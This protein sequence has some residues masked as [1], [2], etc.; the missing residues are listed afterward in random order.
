MISKIL[1]L[2]LVV[3]NVG[4]ILTRTQIKD[5]EDKA[6]FSNKI[7]DLQQKTADDEV[8]LQE[9]Q[10]QLRELLGKSEL[11]E[12]KII[13]ADVNKEGLNES[14]SN[15]FKIYEEAI[16]KVEKDVLQ[17]KNDISELKEIVLALS[18]SIESLKKKKVKAKVEKKAPKGNF[19]SGE[20][21]FGKKK[22][23]QAIEGFRKYRELNPKGKKYRT[24]TYKIGVCFEELKL[25][26]EAK[27]FYDE[28]LEKFPSSR[29]AKKVKVRLK[30]LR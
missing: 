16:L 5:K 1:I 12:K 4:C 17:M 14:N 30:K 7:S 23:K 6:T 9:M 28:V 19:K 24:S 15:K 13:E 27:L 2:I 3:L 21:Y 18:K 20:Y 29:E 22:W 8:R 26:K 25:K 11:I 10:S